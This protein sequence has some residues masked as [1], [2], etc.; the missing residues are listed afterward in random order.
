M[1]YMNIAPEMHSVWILKV[2]LWLSVVHITLQQVFHMS[3]FCLNTSIS[4]MSHCH[5][6]TIPNSWNVP[7]CLKN[8]PK[9][10]FKE[11]PHHPLE[12]NTPTILRGPTSRNPVYLNQ[13]RME[14]GQFG[15]PL[16]IHQPGSFWFRYLQATRLK[17]VGAP[18]CMKCS[19]QRT[20]SGM[21]AKK[22]GMLFSK[23][24]L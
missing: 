15:L 11:F 12:T 18:L 23:T 22:S 20:F 19:P 1:V 24:V 21:L 17:C 14:A 2:C 3:T 9:F 7:Y 6:K 4:L 10:N 16:P 8:P 13:V 5:L